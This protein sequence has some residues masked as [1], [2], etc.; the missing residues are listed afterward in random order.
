VAFRRIDG[1]TWSDIEKDLEVNITESDQIELQI[2]EVIDL[3]LIEDCRT[4]EEWVT[5][6]HK[7]I[8]EGEEAE[9]SVSSE[10]VEEFVNS[11][12]REGKIIWSDSTG[13]IIAL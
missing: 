2:N 3:R 13:S 7:V 10:D 12:M 4:M 6:V 1:E 9:L 11:K 5:E 8:E